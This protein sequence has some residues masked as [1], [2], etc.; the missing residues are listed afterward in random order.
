MLPDYDPHRLGGQ[1]ALTV[2][3]SDKQK[4]QVFT[5]VFLFIPGKIC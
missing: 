1:P 3:I 4:R 5:P 2:K